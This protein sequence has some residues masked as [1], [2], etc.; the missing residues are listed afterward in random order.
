LAAPKCES[1]EGTA[2]A[3]WRWFDTPEQTAQYETWVAFLEQ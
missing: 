2:L 1:Q 3:S